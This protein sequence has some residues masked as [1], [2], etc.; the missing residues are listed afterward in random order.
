[1][2]KSEFL[3]ERSTS[4]ASLDTGVWRPWGCRKGTGTLRAGCGGR[5][6]ESA[7]TVRSAEITLAPRR[8]VVRREARRNIRRVRNSEPTLAGSRGISNGSPICGASSLPQQ[9][10]RRPLTAACSMEKPPNKPPQHR[11][12]PEAQYCG[13]YPRLRGREANNLIGVGSLNL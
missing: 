3:T 1:M 13:Q 2:L 5:H 11:P 12:Q 7:G 4:N 10:T 9:T 8:G 6:R